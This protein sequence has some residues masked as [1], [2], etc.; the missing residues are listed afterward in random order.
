[1]PTASPSAGEKRHRSTALSATGPA[2]VPVEQ[3]IR[4]I[5]HRKWL[6]IHTFVVVLAATIVVSYRLPN[7][8]TSETVIMV[9][10]QKVP[11][12]YVKSTV[13]GDVRNRLGTL[14]QQILSAT[15]LQKIV[16]TLNLYPEQRKK[17]A[18]E[19]VITKMRSDINVSVVSDFGATQ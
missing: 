10:P 8:Y 1:M 16:E 17:L 18:R 3:Y 2:A 15:R 4:L 6:V 11:D 13:T 5:Q 12:A 19:D 14:A 7:L 9:D